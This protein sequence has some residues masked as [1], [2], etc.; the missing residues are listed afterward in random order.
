MRLTDRRAID[1]LRR[2][3][4]MRYRLGKDD[5]VC[6]WMRGL[7]EGP[8]ADGYIVSKTLREGDTDGEGRPITR[9]TIK[10]VYEGDSILTVD[11]L[12][13]DGWTVWRRNPFVPPPAY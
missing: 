9:R 4:V 11:D 12:A 13:S 2:G 1:A 10:D 5:Y 6:V 3:R 8:H 7:A